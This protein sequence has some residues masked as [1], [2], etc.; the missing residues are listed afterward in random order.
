MVT[1][2]TTTL[3]CWC[4]EHGIEVVDFIWMDVQGAEADVFKGGP[5]TLSRTRFLYTEYAD[6]E[7]YEGQ[8]DLRRLLKTLRGFRILTRYPGDVLLANRRLLSEESLSSLGALAR[9]YP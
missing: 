9:R 2:T 6:R 7:L 1:V 3:D 8:L 4:S 5:A